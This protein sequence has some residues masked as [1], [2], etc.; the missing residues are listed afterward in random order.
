MVVENTNSLEVSQAHV[1]AVLDKIRLKPGTTP[2]EFKSA[3]DK[4]C[5]IIA[6]R[7]GIEVPAGYTAEFA[8]A[9]RV[10]IESDPETVKQLNENLPEGIES[11]DEFLNDV[12]ATYKNLVNPAPAA[13]PVGVAAQVDSQ[14][15]APQADA[16]PA[17]AA[18]PVIGKLR[19]ALAAAGKDVGADGVSPEFAR[20]LKEQ[21]I[22][23]QN[24]GNT[25][26][27]DGVYTK[28]AGEAAIAKARYDYRRVAGDISAPDVPPELRTPRA[29]RERLAHI[30]RVVADLN[31][32]HENHPELL[33]QITAQ[34]PVPATETPEP[35]ATSTPAPGETP[36][37]EA[38]AETATVSADF[39]PDVHVLQALLQEVHGKGSIPNMP[40]PGE[41]TGVMKIE[42]E[43]ALYHSLMML[44]A[45]LAIKGAYEEPGQSAD[46][47]EFDGTYVPGET[48]V[49]LKMAIGKLSAADKR[50]FLE[51]LGG[52]QGMEE[53]FEALNRLHEKGKIRNDLAAT[54][55][56]SQQTLMYSQMR[57]KLE[58]TMPGLVEAFRNF[59]TSTPWGQ[60]LGQFLKFFGFDV[61]AILGVE[62]KTSPEQS[63]RD[64]YTDAAARAENDPA[65]TLDIL[66]NNDGG[67]LTRTAM[68]LSMTE[69]QRNL[70]H[71]KIEEAYNQAQGQADP[72]AAFAQY[73]AAQGEAIKAQ[74][75][76][77]RNRDNTIRQNAGA[78][79][80]PSP[81]AAAPAQTPAASAPT[82]PV[83]ANI[84]ALTDALYM[85][86][87]EDTYNVENIDD[88]ISQITQNLKNY[89]RQA[90]VELNS[91]QEIE[92]QRMIADGIND[93]ARVPKGQ[94]SRAFATAMQDN[95]AA[96]Q[97]S[98]APSLA[99][100][101]GGGVSTAPAVE[102]HIDLGSI[103]YAA[104]RES[105]GNMDVLIPVV[106]GALDRFYETQGLVL[107]DEQ[108]AA[109][110]EITAEAAR[111]ARAN[112][113]EPLQ[114]EVFAAEVMKR[115]DERGIDLGV[116]LVD[117]TRTEHT[118]AAPGSPVRQEIIKKAD[119]FL[120]GMPKAADSGVDPGLLEWTEGL[121][122]QAVQN[123]DIKGVRAPLVTDLGSGYAM[124][125]RPA[126]DGTLD[127]RV[128]SLPDY[129]F[130]AGL[131]R[132]L[133]YSPDEIMIVTPQG[134]ESIK[135]LSLREYG[136]AHGQAVYKSGNEQAA[137]QIMASYGSGNP[138]A[139][140]LWEQNR[141][142]RQM[143]NQGAN[144]QGG[145]PGAGGQ[146]IHGG[147]AGGA[148]GRA[149]RME[150]IE[151]L[152]KY[153]LRER[154]INWAHDEYWRHFAG[155]AYRA[156]SEW[157]GAIFADAL[158]VSRARQRG[159]NLRGFNE[160]SQRVAQGEQLA[161]RFGNASAGLSP[162]GENAAT[163]GH[164]FNAR[165]VAAG[166][167][168]TNTGYQVLGRVVGKVHEAGEGNRVY[169]TFL[170][171]RIDHIRLGGHISTVGDSFRLAGVPFG[172]GN[173][174]K[175]L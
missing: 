29:V 52:Q 116:K 123:G 111:T 35:T 3:I 151:L 162:F 50:E 117:L 108:K 68:K 85:R 1:R 127:H 66:Q 87:Y 73:M 126:A 89:H 49:A 57:E 2:A 154:D 135:L 78:P 42:T 100:G 47:P 67:F 175:G 90:G 152:G 92:L 140:L 145:Y 38:P 11:L 51:P 60:A 84:P 138:E 55:H 8:Q 95:I 150:E 18:Q 169:E 6:A 83:M 170:R 153:N 31:D 110:R 129:G 22:E 26:P 142:G 98:E 17:E 165:G 41:P 118:A 107:S 82:V 147:Y 27:L 13:A 161:H 139:Y 130:M 28:E 133:G 168:N 155:D 174:W 106:H 9:A 23:L 75:D 113:R 149:Q 134:D 172:V 34:A 62:Q 79:Q 37:G 94:E 21:I 65:K 58:Q 144:Y 124:V 164:Y 24:L 77:N 44:K 137:R 131:D 159:Q 158:E 53:M 143:P 69:E 166:L 54:F 10:K 15:H 25:L 43:A 45:G 74:N 39:D 48:D 91:E 114:G 72:A 122:R 46:S 36:A 30:E 20:A 88:R 105:N 156:N 61:F 5:M 40:D 104:L 7:L 14:N 86:A 32:L 71:S 141:M 121:Y 93:A 102:V 64:L 76:N 33:T 119:Q 173:P 148:N 4:A 99:P 19:A 96:Q 136:Y 167:L 16:T 163:M 132:A 171:D 146:M 112:A 157:G 63:F 56:I 120:A 103:Y 128:I 160:A 80:I 59:F 81:G 125:T 70:W 109:M 97:R 101:G 115:M 12:E